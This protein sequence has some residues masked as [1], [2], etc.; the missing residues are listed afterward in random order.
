M[1]RPMRQHCSCASPALHLP[2]GTARTGAETA[3]RCLQSCTFYPSPLISPTKPV[4]LPLCPH[5]Q[6]IYPRQSQGYRVPDKQEAF[7]SPIM[8]SKALDIRR[9]VCPF[10]CIATNPAKIMMM[11]ATISELCVSPLEQQHSRGANRP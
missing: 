4:L 2:K 3:P 5:L 6:Q 1:W 11:I 8:C 7:P 10:H 9:T